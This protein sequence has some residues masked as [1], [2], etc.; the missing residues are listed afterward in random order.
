MKLNA[1]QTEVGKLAHKL[2]D[3]HGLTNWRLRWTDS[4]SILGVCRADS[5]ELSLP[6]VIINPISVARDTILHEIA[7]ALCGIDEGHGKKWK[8]KCIE[9]GTGSERCAVDD[10]I[11]HPTQRTIKWK[12]EHTYTCPVCK[13]WRKQN[14]KTSN[15]YCRCNGKWNE[16]VCVTV[17]L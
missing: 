12:R 17:E 13:R 1:T 9:I 5:I 6:Y 3:K 10:N 2:M 7:H 11:S 4:K 14:I 8:Q 16:F 15:G